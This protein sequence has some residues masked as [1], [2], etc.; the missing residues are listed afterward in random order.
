MAS[1]TDRTAFSPAG[2]ERTQSMG[3]G[4]LSD[5]GPEAAMQV[6]QLT[7]KM[8]G[9]F[10][11]YYAH[12]GEELLYANAA[13]LRLFGCD[14]AEQFRALTG[15]SFR[16]MVHPDDLEDVEKSIWE[17]ISE[18][19]YDLDYVEYRIVRRDGSVR[20]VED[21]GHFARNDYVGDIFY[22][23][24]ADATDK[25]LHRQAVLGQK[26]RE[27]EALTLE[28]SR[29]L[30]II[31][32]LSVDYESILSLDLDADV[33]QPYRMS[34]RV[35]ELLRGLSAPYRFQDFAK[36][37][38]AACVS[39]EDRE[40]MGRVLTVRHLRERLSRQSTY[41]VTY[42]VAGPAGPEYLQL[43]CVNV[44]GGAQAGRIM[45]GVR[46]VD[47]E[48]VLQL[49]QKRLLEDALRRAH[50]AEIARSTFLSNMS[51]DIRTPLNAVMGFAALARAH[52]ND[53]EQ[54]LHDMDL[55][56]E[57]G[58]QLLQ[59]LS[60]VLELS[61]LESGQVSLEE[62]PCRL[63]EL[64]GKVED[65]I[66]PQAERKNIRL[67][68]DLSGMT[69]G[70]VCGDRSRL[71]QV[72]LCLA[73]NAVKYTPPGGRVVLS[74]RQ[75]FRE[76]RDY[77]VCR[78]AVED[79]GVGISREFM[80]HL[81]EP[82]EREQNTT[83]CGVQGSGLGLPIARGLVEM[84]GGT[85]DVES[86][87]GKGSTFTL[88]LSMRLYRPEPQECPQADEPAPETFAGMRLLLVEDNQINVM[89]ESELLEEAGF[90]VEVAGDGREAVDKVE[91]SAP[92]YYRLIL[93]DIQMPVMDGR[94][95][96]RAIRALEEPA[97]ASIP[98]IALSA[99]AFEQD[100]RQSLECGMEAHLPKPLHIPQLLEQITRIMGERKG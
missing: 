61:R 64:V 88:T 18:N 82:F 71:A 86:E 35:A 83:L 75:E 44:D 58:E 2:G 94:E 65:A 100:V 3:L 99:N 12:G 98:I 55:I 15:N 93:M 73:D 63:A 30:E 7:E 57:S 14:T 31:R 54:V 46:M 24:L 89:I 87:P 70:E 96:A 91:R 53:P 56:Q 32:G 8:P 11:I 43:R 45:L 27:L 36:K 51:H 97:L 29:S 62:A 20:W 19:S 77:C 13:L 25:Q 76:M 37:Y 38:V 92:G 28:R 52:A 69:H 90:V 5:L 41:H 59:L 74:L 16:G 42:R 50:A 1:E 40:L 47:S 81:Y 9:G 34:G 4:R 6:R 23:F 85:L 21:Y 22:V 66:R 79:T 39:P 80:R 78:F 33:L 26:D 10:F 49:D 17:Q 95:A 68:V 84:M 72:L 67:S 48:I 60:A